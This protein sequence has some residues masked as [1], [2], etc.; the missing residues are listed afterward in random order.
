MSKM[1]REVVIG[2]A[3]AVVI[4]AVLGLSYQQ[5]EQANYKEAFM[6]AC[7]DTGGEVEGID[8]KQ[9]CECAFNALDKQVGIKN[10]KDNHYTSEEAEE[11]M[12]PYGMM[13]LTEQGFFNN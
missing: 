13:C 7:L 3:V 9:F 2:I 8:K 5:S 11:I 10:I 12:K 4:T 6:T 1:K